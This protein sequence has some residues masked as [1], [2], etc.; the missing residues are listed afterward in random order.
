MRN[1]RLQLVA[2]PTPIGRLRARLLGSCGGALVLA[3][4]HVPLARGQ[5]LP[6]GGQVVGGA[7]QINAAAQ[8]L[9]VTQTS[10][11]AAIDWASF[12]IG[13]GATVVFD[14]PGAHAV[15]LNRVMGTAPSDIHGALKANGQ[16]FLL[17]PNGVLFGKTAQVNVGSLL[18]STGA[19]SD[20]DF[21]AGN[22]RITGAT[23]RTIVNQ[24]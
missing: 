21:A 19:I 18:V 14:Q 22:Y 20:D 5:A 10:A 12:N 8:V 1:A 6:T 2:L 11:R 24:G 15:A 17:N 4:G 9:T 3:F 16:V 13:A 7:A 23:D